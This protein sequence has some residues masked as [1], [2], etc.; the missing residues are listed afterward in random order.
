MA[1][2]GERKRLERLHAVELKTKAPGRY[3]DGAGLW[4]HVGPT[5]GRSWVMR[6]MLNG[7]AREMGLGAL[8]TFSLAEAR[9]KA[10]SVRQLLQDGLDP[11]DQ[12]QAE[13]DRSRA[14]MTGRRTF[15][16]CA[17]GYILSNASGWR[18]AKHRAQWESTLEAYAYPTMG[19][20]PVSVIDTSH[21]LKCLESI[22]QTKTETASRVRGRI[23]SVLDY[24]AARR[25]RSGDNPA[26]WRG[27][28]D[29]LLPKRSKVQRVEHHAALPY[30]E[31]GDFMTALREMEGTSAR[32]LEFAILTAART[33]E[34]I[35]ATWPEFD[36]QAKLWTVP[37]ERMKAGREHRV[38]LSER[39]LSI[40]RALPRED[41]NPFVFIGPRAGR[42]LS[43]MAL[44]ATLRRMERG[45]LT[46]HGFR[47]TFRDWCAEMTGT[48]HEVAEMALAHVVG[49]K[50]EAAYR[51]GDLF[52]KRR[53]LM[54]EWAAFCARKPSATGKVVSI[55]REM[56]KRP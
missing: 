51:R 29:Q 13:R 24:A 43:N 22:W 55:R 7:K 16:Q 27:H 28:L 11:I 40:L 9:T 38:P 53:R 46:S 8:H 14:E 44:L 17:D 47:S 52:E 34:V 50:V 15:R 21:V 12:R 6:Y 33:G 26:R 31:L 5:G 39:A 41:K 4:F 20:L 10:R 2:H 45:D 32:A 3:A 25:Y 1:N 23:E 36:L 48:P 18:N 49:D 35:A 42:G 19:D 56:A 30:A 37:G 54:S